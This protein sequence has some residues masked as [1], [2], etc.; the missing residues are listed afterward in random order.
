MKK[1]LLFF[2]ILF[3]FTIISCKNEN[4]AETEEM[5]AP[6]ESTIADNDINAPQ[7][8]CY[9]YVSAKDTILLQMEK[10]DDEVAG[11]LS[12]NYFEKDRNDGTFEG[13]M[14]EDTLFAS[15]TFGSEGKTS[16]REIIFIENGKKLIEGF[17]EVE[18]IDGKMQFKKNTKFIFNSLMPLEQINCDEN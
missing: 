2:A 18:E 4:K 9:K 1:Y 6:D 5:M 11:T 12:Y 7:I 14:V 8:A 17:G 10:M 16:V 15:Y 13:K 3:T